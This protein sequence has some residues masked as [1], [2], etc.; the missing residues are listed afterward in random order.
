[1]APVPGSAERLVERFGVTSSA[2]ELVPEVV[3]SPTWRSDLGFL[4]ESEVIRSLAES[5]DL[6]LFRPFPDSETAELLVLHETSR[7]IVGLQIKT[8]GTDAAN[9]AG[10]VTVLASSLRTSPTTYFVVLAWQHDAA[11]FFDDCLLVPSEKLGDIANKDAYGHIK[12]EFHAG[13]SAHGRL[14][15]FRR[16]LSALKDEIAGLLTGVRL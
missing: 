11:R 3:P 7:H 13:S 12:F 2:I 5:D 10:T 6:N 14:D 9:P 8:V 1:M 4:G 16:R 15:P